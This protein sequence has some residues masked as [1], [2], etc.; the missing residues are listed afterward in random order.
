MGRRTLASA[1]LLGGLGCVAGAI[2]ANSGCVT[3]PPPDLPKP[4]QH[5][6]TILHGSV[7]PPPDEVLT[8]WPADGTFLVPVEL[9]DNNA[10]FYYDAFIDYNPYTNSKPVFL[11]VAVPGVTAYDG[12]VTIIAFSM[13]PPDSVLCHRVEFLVAHQF[14]TNSEHT[15]DSIGGD[16]VSWLYNPGGGPN[17]C[18]VYD[19]GALQDG[20]FVDSAPSGLP[21]VPDSGADP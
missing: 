16:I 2:A 10:I 4:R 20:A 3:A 19:A 18:P 14:N 15:P 1:L 11:R 17:G 12:G 21:L 5:R 13:T 9:E 6:P 7:V 8:Q